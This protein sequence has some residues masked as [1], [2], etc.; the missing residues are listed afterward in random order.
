MSQRSFQPDADVICWRIFFRSA[1]EHVYQTL[2]TPEGRSA[3]WAESAVEEDGI[4]H[5][6]LPGGLAT[7]GHILETESCRSFVVEYFG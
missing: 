2:A 4:I 7:R 6:S 5:F 1:P 3:F